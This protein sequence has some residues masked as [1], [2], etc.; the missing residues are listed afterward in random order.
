MVRPGLGIVIPALNEQETI[1]TVIKDL[2][3]YGIVIVVDD[4]SKDQTASLAEKAG[5]VVVSHPIN[6]GYDAAIE[7]GI[8][9]AKEL[10]LAYVVTFDADGQH[11]H[12]LIDAFYQKLA[13]SSDLV[14]GIRP[15]K[16]RIMEV[17][18]GIYFKTRFGVEDILCGMKGYRTKLFDQN[19][20]FDH[21][22]S[23]GT[24]LAMMSIKRGACFS[25][26]PVP[27]A[28]R[29]DHPRFG[30]IISSNGKIARALWALI[31]LDYSS[32]KLSSH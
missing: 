4:G 9:K 24:E 12:H 8:K 11:D 22:N 10:N 27:M 21:I 6:Q 2:V 23:V 29:D 18:L 32:R 3:T 17:I 7:S 30:N 19:Q 25:Q 15:H 31:K 28:K 13:N 14:L 26:I 1:E 16:Q 5:A 20:G